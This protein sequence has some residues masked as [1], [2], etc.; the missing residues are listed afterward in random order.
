MPDREITSAVYGVTERDIAKEAIDLD[1]ERV[2]RVGC[3]VI[4]GGFTDAD[5]DDFSIRL[6]AVLEQQVAEFGRDRLEAIGDRQTARCP[7]VYD[8][9][10]LRLAAHAGVLAIV[11]RLL[12][13]YV[14]LMQQ[15]GVFNAPSQD[16]TQRA[17]HRDL[18][19]QHW[20]SSEPLAISALFCLDPFRLETGATT[21]LPGSHKFERFPSERLAAEIDMPVVA[22][23][24]SFVVFD[25]MLFHRAGVNRTE[26]MRRAVNH[27]YTIPLIGQQISL[28]AALGGRY[29]DEPALARLL[30]YDNAPAPSVTG[31]RERRLR[32]TRVSTPDR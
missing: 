8:E 10:F 19:Y 6:D 18:P 3:T 23:R 5:M 25:S 26:G 4:A 16:H 21:V 7:L 17:Y 29:S 20:V 27:V 31:W 9:A 24:G 32:R 2:R 22:D 15:N 13:E 11:H 30:G 28:P 14:V 12:G 1:V